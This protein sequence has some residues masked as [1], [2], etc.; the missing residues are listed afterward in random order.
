MSFT[1]SMLQRLLGYLRGE[2]DWVLGLFLFVLVVIR[3]VQV[4]LRDRKLPPGP[5]GVPFLGYL[6]FVKT[7][8]HLLFKKMARKYGPTFSFRFGSHLIVVLSDFR[9]IRSAFRKECFS[10]RP[11]N[12]I[13]QIIEGFGLINSDGKLWKGQRKFLHEKLRNFGM[14]QM[15]QGREQLEARIMVEVD[16]FLNTMLLNRG[17]PVNLSQFLTVNISNVICSLLMSVRFTR[18][19]ARFKK[20]TELIEEGFRLCTSTGSTNFIPSLKYLPEIKEINGK[21]QQNRA[22]MAGFFREIVEEHKATFDPSNIRDVVDSYLL[23]IETAKAEGRD[24][25]LFE[26]KDPDRQIYQ[27]LGDMYSAG[28]ETVKTAMSWAVLY[29]LH[30]PEVLKNVQKELDQVV[31]RERLPTLDDMSQLP[32]TEATVLEVLRRACIV[33]LGTTHSTT[34]DVILD[35]YVIPK[36]TQVIPSLYSVSMDEELWEDPEE[37]NPSRFLNEA[38]AVDKPDFWMPF[39]AGRRMCLGDTLAKQELYLFFTSLVHCFHLQQVEGAVLPDL[40]GV[41]AVTICPGEYDLIAIPRSDDSSSSK[42]VGGGDCP[43]VNSSALS[44]KSQALLSSC[45]LLERRNAGQH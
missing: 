38:G 14:R 26:G 22:E 45:P 7:P 19:D 40:V 5:W 9:T 44:V 41:A 28:M 10:G 18:D 3:G 8:P 11:E 13:S 15:G 4:V 23:E 1:W 2:V 30:Y 33:P 42:K 35:G 31:G 25:Y 37:F 32:Y 6:P 27:I 20:F 29:M 17:T 43:L 39:G 12:E 34:K 21:I 24:E 36:N 16:E